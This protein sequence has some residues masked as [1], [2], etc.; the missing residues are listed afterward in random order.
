[1]RVWR[2]EPVILRMAVNLPEVG[3]KFFSGMDRLLRF[4]PLLAAAFLLAFAATL[5]AQ[6]A[7]TPLQSTAPAVPQVPPQTAPPSSPE[8]TKAADQVL[9]QM[10][11]I[12]DLPIIEPLKKSLRSKQEVRD[13]LVREEKEDRT[14]AERYAD[15][16]TLEAFG[17][18]PKGF[19]L[20]SFMLD[21]LTDQVA[22]LYD[23]KAKEFYIADWIPANEQRTV[24][25]HE[26]THALEDQSFHIDPWIKAARPNDD[27]E[28][29]RDAVSEGSAMAA[30][31]DY[32]MIDQKM[33]VR[34]MPDVTLMIRAGAVSEMDKDPNLSK[35]PPF[36][37]D[38]LLFPYLAGTGFTQQ[39]LKAHSGWKDLHLIF[40]NPP[41]STQQILHPDLYLH[42]VKPE[43]LV[44]PEWKGVVPDDW[45]LL[46]ENTIGEFGLNEI[47]KQLLDV[48]RADF[49]SPSWKG[50]RY[51]T[52]ED[53]KTQSNPLV[54]LVAL[55]NADDAGHYFSEYGEALERKYKARTD[56]FRRPDF[57]QFQS[58]SGGVFLRCV[59]THCVSVEGATRETFDKITQA[60]GWPAA[61]AAVNAKAAP[62]AV[63]QKE[64][65][66]ASSI[67][68][69]GA[70][71]H[72]GI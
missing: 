27:A 54:F 68:S 24:M 35:A 38:E 47:L 37:R 4:K 28:L 41:V 18:I 1:M 65:P 2:E 49:L 9:E 32:Q 34:D 19:P 3:M 26:L 31:V 55:D 14:E 61:P 51:A 58:E 23:P 7:A 48:N 50:D 5:P 39:F 10:S 33:G 52:F 29:A 67:H 72:P 46:E 59:A 69:N 45:K 62:Q 25:S 30:M 64:N 36:I 11:K 6:N 12:L 60:L 56:V 17:L 20:D 43:A 66:T 13:Y 8:F 22:G 15:D 16:K 40:Q 57:F 70:A 44:L 42:G 71:T 21:V 53:A 63:T